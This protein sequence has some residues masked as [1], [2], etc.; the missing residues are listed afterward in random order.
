MCIHKFPMVAGS[1]N[2]SGSYESQQAKEDLSSF[3]QLPCT[4]ALISTCFGVIFLLTSLVTCCPSTTSF[5]SLCSLFRL[6]P[7]L[8]VPY[9]LDQLRTAVRYPV[10][11]SGIM[12]L[13]SPSFPLPSPLTTSPP[14]TS[15][16]LLFLCSAED[17]TCVWGYRNRYFTLNCVIASAVFNIILRYYIII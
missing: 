12:R 13:P 1:F 3:G 6:H 10:C 9:P 7:L 17:R 16:Q 14:L 5:Q 8:S 4:A 11:A 15:L 2:L